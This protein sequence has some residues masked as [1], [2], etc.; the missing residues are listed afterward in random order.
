M[1]VTFNLDKCFGK[2]MYTYLSCFHD[3]NGEDG[4]EL[5]LVHDLCNIELQSCQ[6]KI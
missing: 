3:G 4:F 5:Y 6:V 1:N 2:I